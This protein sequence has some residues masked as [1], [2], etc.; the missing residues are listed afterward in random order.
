MLI[1]VVAN[2]VMLIKEKISGLCLKAKYRAIK[3]KKKIVKKRQDKKAEVRRKKS[4]KAVKVRVVKSKRAEML[5]LGDE[6]DELRQTRES[7]FNR[8]ARDEIPFLPLPEASKKKKSR[9]VKLPSEIK[10]LPEELDEAHPEFTEMVQE[11][12]QKV[13]TRN[14]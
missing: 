1:N 3:T 8:S 12:I 4:F 11:K 2:M 13:Q 9:P 14:L 6:E 7:A 10:E 5:T